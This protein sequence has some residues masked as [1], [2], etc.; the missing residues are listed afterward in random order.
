MKFKKVNGEWYVVVFLSP[1]QV[2][3]REDVPV[4]GVDV[5]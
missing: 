4:V 2:D 5:D 3:V 1:P